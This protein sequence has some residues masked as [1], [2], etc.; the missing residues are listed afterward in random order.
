MWAE[1]LGHVLCYSVMRDYEVTEETWVHVSRNSIKR[2]AF[3]DDKFRFSW[4]ASNN[5]S[6][7]VPKFQNIEAVMTVSK[8]TI[9]NV[10]KKTI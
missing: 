9:K 8:D 3:Y 6:S 5:S 4:V 2:N 1:F 7:F 10:E